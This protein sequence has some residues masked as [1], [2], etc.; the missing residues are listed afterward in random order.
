MLLKELE[1]PSELIQKAIANGVETVAEYK[2]WLNGYADGY[3][4]GVNAALDRAN[5]F[6][7]ED[8]K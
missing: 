7:L 4:D 1:Y 5:D 3:S 2:I 8:V 6:D